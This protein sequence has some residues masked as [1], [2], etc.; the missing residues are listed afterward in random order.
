MSERFK[1]RDGRGVVTL[2]MEDQEKYLVKHAQTLVV[3]CADMEDVNASRKS[4][5]RDWS[6]DQAQSVTQVTRDLV[7]YMA[8]KADFEAVKMV[9]KGSVCVCKKEQDVNV[10]VREM[11]IS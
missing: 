8:E 10:V 3:L 1:H 2:E 5:T 9:I 6:S 7:E 4:V 11:F